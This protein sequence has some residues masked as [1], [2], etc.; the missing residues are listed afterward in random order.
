[1]LVALSVPE[2]VVPLP[3]PDN[4][5]GSVDAASAT[6]VSAVPALSLV[7][8][9]VSVVVCAVVIVPGL[10]AAVTVGGAT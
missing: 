4:P 8:V 5:A 9:T 3:D 7:S 2:Q 10:N 1:M 6:P